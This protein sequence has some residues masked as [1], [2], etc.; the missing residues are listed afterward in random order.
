MPVAIFARLKSQPNLLNYAAKEE[1][2]EREREGRI[3]IL[4]L[5]CVKAPFS[6]LPFPVSLAT[7]HDIIVG[8]EVTHHLR[9]VAEP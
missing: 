9:I 7:S 5:S 2:K 6:L 1:E 3:R 8:P 4:V